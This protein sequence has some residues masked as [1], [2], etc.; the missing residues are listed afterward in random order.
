MRSLL[1]LPGNDRLYVKKF[2]DL[3][4]FEDLKTYIYK[5]SNVLPI[6][7]V[8]KTDKNNHNHRFAFV[9][10]EKPDDAKLV[11]EVSQDHSVN[12]RKFIF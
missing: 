6:S 9:S 2:P 4:T 7:C 5:F 8:I 12:V 10:F 1:S 3:M 11:F